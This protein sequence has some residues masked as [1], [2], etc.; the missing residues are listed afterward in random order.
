MKKDSFIVGKCVGKTVLDLGYVNED[1]G[2]TLH[3]KILEV[4]KSVDGVDELPLKTGNNYYVGNVEKIE[5][6]LPQKIYDVIVAGDIIEHVFN[7][8]LFLDSIKIYCDENTEIIITT[9]NCFS[10]RYTLPHYFK[11]KENVSPYHVLWHSEKTLR[12]LFGFKDFEIKEF[13]YRDYHRLT[14]IRPIIKL[15]FK[16]I[17][18]RFNCGLIFVVGVK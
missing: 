5:Y 15:A 4:A 16:K 2:D 3:Q 11:G 6:F 14:G 10:T 1:L 9:P 12:Q 7:Q 18:K 17:F 13:H 8:G